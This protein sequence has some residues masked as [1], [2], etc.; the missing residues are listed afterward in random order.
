MIFELIFVVIR[1]LVR[2]TGENG[3]ELVRCCAC[4]LVFKWMLCF[5]VMPILLCQQT[6]F[7]FE[8]LKISRQSMMETIETSN[9]RIDVLQ[10]VQTHLVDRASSDL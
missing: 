4:N 1:I 2:T 3:T 9:G 7:T 6:I 8:C 10:V 5:R